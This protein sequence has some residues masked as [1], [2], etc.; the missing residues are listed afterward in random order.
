[1]TPARFQAC[2]QYLKLSDAQIVRY[3]DMS[4]G[5]VRRWKNGTRDI[6]PDVG[7]W[8]E[9]LVRYWEA[10]PPPALR[11]RVRYTRDDDEAA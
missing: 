6:P 2:L 4:D 7:D 9:R 3:L 1:M 5:L 10:N 11:G 8:I